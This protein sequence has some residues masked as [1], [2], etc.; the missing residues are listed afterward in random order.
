M[1]DELA[2]EFLIESQEELDRMERCLTDL[3]KGPGDAEL[4]AEIFRS[5]HTDSLTTT[6]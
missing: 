5:V 6:S 4:I 3:E 2:R 1:I